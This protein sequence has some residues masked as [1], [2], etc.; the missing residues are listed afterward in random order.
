MAP[1]STPP[2]RS[3]AAA[4]V[5]LLGAGL[6]Y[7]ACSSV[8]RPPAPAPSALAASAGVPRNQN[9]SGADRPP[10]ILLVMADQFRHDAMSGGLVPYPKT[11]ALDR[12]RREGAWFELHYT[13]TPSCTPSRAAIL[14]GRSPWRHGMLGFGDIALSY[15]CAELPR[16]LKS[17]GYRTVSVGKFRGLPCQ[18]GWEQVKKESGAAGADRWCAQVTNCE[19]GAL[20]APAAAG[21]TAVA[22]PPEEC[23]FKLISI[24]TC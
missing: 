24:G 10:H 18:H 6:L 2:S 16:A 20:K 19:L 22:A 15:P 5:P 3:W 17:A 21:A 23:K 9:Q 11:P 12:L 8:I 7:A 4:A 1:P 13:S 14:T